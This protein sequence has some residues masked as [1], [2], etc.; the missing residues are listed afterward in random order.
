V[1]RS[2]SVANGDGLEAT[3]TK[4]D[5]FSGIWAQAEGPNVSLWGTAAN[6]APRS[7]H[8]PHT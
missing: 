5:G 2:G 6:S 3:G 7:G 4:K 1:R 8:V